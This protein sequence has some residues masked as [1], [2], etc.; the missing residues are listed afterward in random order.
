[1]IGVY[2]SFEEINFEE[3]PNQFVI[4]CTHDS[5]G[6]V[7]CKNKS[8]F[9]IRKAKEKIKK[10]MKRN[11]YYSGREWPYKNI[12]PKIIIEQYMEDKKAKELIDFK[13]MCFNGIP[14]FS[15]TC[16]ERYNDGLKV[17]FYNLSWEKMSFERHYPSSTKNIEKPKNYELMLELSKKLSKNIPFVRVDW[18]EING[19]LYFGEL[20]F[21][22]GSGLEEFKPFSWD[23]KLGNLLSLEKIGWYNE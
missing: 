6:V 13:I 20:T 19:K 11:F 23:K 8:K 2:N 10:S 4:K 7:I 15:F 1:M 14:K 21:Y 16:S 3:L 17:T 18:Y 9:D 22:P 12:K 5:G